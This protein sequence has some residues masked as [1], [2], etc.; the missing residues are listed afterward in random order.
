MVWP[1]AAIIGYGPGRCG[2]GPMAAIRDLLCL[3]QLLDT[4]LGQKKLQI[5]IWLR[6]R[7][8]INAAIIGNGHVG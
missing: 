8:A 2:N 6:P 4:L 7:S 3:P 1:D 5:L